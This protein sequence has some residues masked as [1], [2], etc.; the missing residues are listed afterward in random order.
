MLIEPV[1]RDEKTRKVVDDLMQT[2]SDADCPDFEKRS[3]RGSLQYLYSQSI[4]QAGRSLVSRL[5]T[6]TYRDQ[7]ADKFFRSCYSMRSD[8]VHGNQPQP[9]RQDVVRSNIY[10]EQMVGHLLCG[11]LIDSVSDDQID[12]QTERVR[13]RRQDG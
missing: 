13:A 6:R 9:S 12:E 3:I 10:L 8:I 7:A 11:E 4:N 5:G 2:V 1:V